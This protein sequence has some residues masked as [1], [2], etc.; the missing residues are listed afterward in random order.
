MQFLG[1]LRRLTSS[2]QSI[3]KVV[4]FALKYG[5][6]CGEDLWDCLVEECQKVHIISFLG[7]VVLP[8]YVIPSTND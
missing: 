4:G 6:K 3:Q 7:V 8:I 5:E 2:Q 1:V